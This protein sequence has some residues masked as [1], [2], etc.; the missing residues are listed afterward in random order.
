[1]WVY[2]VYSFAVFFLFEKMNQAKN[3]DS[4][5]MVANAKTLDLTELEGLN[6]TP[7]TLTESKIDKYVS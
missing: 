6:K 4:K 5:R 3:P 7:K 1:M 2:P